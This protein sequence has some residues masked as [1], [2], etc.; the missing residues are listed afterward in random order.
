M[1]AWEHQYS[2]MSHV[3]VPVQVMKQFWNL[4]LNPGVCCCWTIQPSVNSCLCSSHWMAHI[5]HSKAIIY[6]TACFRNSLFTF[7]LINNYEYGEKRWSVLEHT[8]VACWEPT[9]SRFGLFGLVQSATFPIK[10]SNLWFQQ[11]M[12]QC[13]KTLNA[14]LPPKHVHGLTSKHILEMNVTWDVAHK[15]NWATWAF[16]L[17][18]HLITL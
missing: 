12:W 7:L 10:S 8:S 3:N 9:S 17:P 15:T 2:L 5:R 16:S 1:H 14:P 13:R 11:L 6:S 4:T 18:P